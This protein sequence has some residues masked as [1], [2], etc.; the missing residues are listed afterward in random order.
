M[1]KSMV[2]EAYPTRVK[3]LKPVEILLFNLGF[4][5][6]CHVSCKYALQM[7]HVQTKCGAKMTARAR[8]LPRNNFTG[9]SV[10]NRIEPD[11]FY[12]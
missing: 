4:S 12:L 11:P 10:P 3:S 6:P 7:I 2:R 8:S 1:H 9:F 5:L